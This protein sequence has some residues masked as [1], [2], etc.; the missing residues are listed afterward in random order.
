MQEHW[1]PAQ[2]TLNVKMPAF[3]KGRSQLS[4]LDVESTRGLASVRIH[5]ERV[6]G[7]TRHKYVNM[8]YSGQLFLPQCVW[9]I[10]QV[11]KPYTHPATK[12]LNAISYYNSYKSCTFQPYQGGSMVIGHYRLLLNFCA[13]YR[14]FNYL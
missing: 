4:A 7:M 10:A 2:P 6:I 1:G 9:R 5:V 3:T 8:P 12:Y 14:L 11:Y 13:L